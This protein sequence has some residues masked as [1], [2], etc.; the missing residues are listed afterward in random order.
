MLAGRGLEANLVSTL[1]RGRTDVAQEVGNGRVAAAIAEVLQ[2]AEKPAAGEPGISR[3][4]FAKIGCEG[5]D[6]RLTRLARSVG[7]SLEPARNVFA[8]RLAVDPALPGDRRHR[9][10][11]PMQIQYH[12]HLPD[13]DHRIPLPTIRRSIN[14]YAPPVSR[15][16]LRKTGGSA[17]LGKIQTH[18][19]G[20]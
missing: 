10:A 6:H 5:I 17:I 15:S 12:H 7:R 13:L 1:R 8:H 2:F 11:L 9:Q 14:D 4:P 20:Y 19:W 3:D 18:F 16:A